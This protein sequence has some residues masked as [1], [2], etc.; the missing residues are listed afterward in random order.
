MRS[1]AFSSISRRSEEGFGP[2]YLLR[3]ACL[4]LVLVCL[5]KPRVES[6]ER[7]RCYC[8]LTWALCGWPLSVRLHIHKPELHLLLPLKRATVGLRKCLQRAHD[9]PPVAHLVD[10]EAVVELLAKSI[11]VVLVIL[12]QV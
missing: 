8:A 11:L 6:R 12:S 2:L 1:A 3:F 10:S 7:G 5:D 4:V 9:A